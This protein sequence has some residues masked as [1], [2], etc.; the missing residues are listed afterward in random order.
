MATLTTL[1]LDGDGAIDATIQHDS[2]TGSPF[3]THCNDDPDS[4]SADFVEN[5]GSPGTHTARFTLTNVDSDFGSMDTFQIRVD[6]DGDFVIGQTA[7]IN[8]RIFSGAGSSTPLTDKVK[9]VDAT[10]SRSVANISFTGLTG[11]KSQWD[12]AQVEFEWENVSLNGERL[13][14][15]GCDF[16]GTYTEAAPAGPDSPLLT[17]NNT[18][19]NNGGESCINYPSI[20][21]EKGI[22]WESVASIF[23]NSGDPTT[24]GNV[25]SDRLRSFRYY[26]GDNG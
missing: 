4:S 5:D 9:I 12:D 13:Q 20:L 6:R 14:L 25:L 22:G 16:D 1:T 19:I 11:T 23:P 8:A 21:G 3:Y 7:I 24:Y 17:I 2:G 10:D 15:F 26:G 18:G